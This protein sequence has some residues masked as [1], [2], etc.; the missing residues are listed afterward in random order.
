LLNFHFENTLK[1]GFK[2]TNQPVDD[3]TLLALWK[4][5]TET[6]PAAVDVRLPAVATWEAVRAANTP[7]P[8]FRPPALRKAPK[9][10]SLANGN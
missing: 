6:L 7:R 10:A 5:A 1:I 3:G 9:N 8:A 4:L 2:P